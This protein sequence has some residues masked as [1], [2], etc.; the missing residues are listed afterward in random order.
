MDIVSE[1]AVARHGD[2]NYDPSLIGTLS[3]YIFDK[4]W[5]KVG[6]LQIANNNYQ[7]NRHNNV[8]HYVV[9][10]LQP[11]SGTSKPGTNI[12][13]IEFGIVLHL[14]ISAV[15]NLSFRDKGKNLGYQ[16]LYKVNNIVVK[17]ELRGLGIA[18]A[19]YK[20]LVD[21]KVFILGD[22][23]QYFGARRLWAT[24]SREMDVVVDIVDYDR[25]IVIERNVILHH[26]QYDADFDQRVWSYNE[27]KQH[28]RLVLRDV[29]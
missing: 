26:G 11:Y 28:I 22:R 10:Q 17:P 7:I 20:W 3:K 13:K 4:N 6:N 25:E 18:K 29:V 27:D 21:Q 15:A 16:N 1:H 23:E 8:P 2:L 24:L 5:S 14:Q 19:M 12:G 9:G